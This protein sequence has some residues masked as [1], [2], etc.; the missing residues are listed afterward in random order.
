MPVGEIMISVLDRSE[1]SRTRCES[2]TCVRDEDPT[3]LC[4]WF[5]PQMGA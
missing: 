3:Q 2:S 4:T 5:A 1:V